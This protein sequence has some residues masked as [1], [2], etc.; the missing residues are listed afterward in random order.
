MKLAEF[1]IQIKTS[2]TNNICKTCCK[3]VINDFMKYSDN[4][5]IILLIINI[6]TKFAIYIKKSLIICHY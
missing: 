2:L 5:L 3:W 1:G 6:G 4:N